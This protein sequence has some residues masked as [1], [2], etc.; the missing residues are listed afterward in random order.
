M[1]VGHANGRLFLNIAGAGFDAAVGAA[2]HERGE[3]GGRRGVTTY[4]A[5]S[6]RMFFSHPASPFLLECG[7]GGRLEGRAFLVAVAN[8][9]Q[10]GGGAVVAPRARLDDG[11]LDFFVIDEASPREIL[12]G[13]G[14]MF[15]GRIEGFR[16]YRHLQACAATFTFPSPLEY[17]CDGEPEGQTD[18]LRVELEPRALRVRV[19]SAAATAR[20]GPFT[21]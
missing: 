15:L 6:L 2:F 11:L 5:L 21:S 3:R 12:L 9:K 10:Y 14:R 13:A 16:R 4:V 19:P 17:H 8:G 20:D 7:E 1:D 18:S